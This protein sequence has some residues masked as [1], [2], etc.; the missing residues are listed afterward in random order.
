[1]RPEPENLS[2]RFRR[3]MINTFISLH[4]FHALTTALW[5]VCHAIA[6]SCPKHGLMMSLLRPGETLPQSAA[7]KFLFA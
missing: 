2:A 5:T 6:P 7:G 1:M 4:R 3:I